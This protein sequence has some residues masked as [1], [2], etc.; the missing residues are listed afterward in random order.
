VDLGFSVN[1]APEQT[2]LDRLTDQ[3]FAAAFG[4]VK[5]QLARTRDQID[6]NVSMGRVGR[7][8]YPALILIIA[9]ALGLEMLVANRFY[10]K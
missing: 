7:E 2:R 5:F 9:L 8:L 10:K 1:Y 6:R 3:E 4:P